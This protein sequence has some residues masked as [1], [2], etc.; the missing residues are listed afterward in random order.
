M[1]QVR[2]GV[3]ELAGLQVGPVVALNILRYGRS[4]RAPTDGK[5]REVEYAKS[6]CRWGL[7]ALLLCSFA[8]GG[9]FQGTGAPT[10]GVPYRAQEQ[11]NYCVPASIAMWR[12]YDG[13]P[14]MSQTQIWNALG[15]PPCTG[16]DA[17]FGVRQ[18]TSS[19]IDAFLNTT[20]PSQRDEFFGRQ[21][22]SIDSR[23]P[24]MVIVSSFRNHVGIINGGSYYLTG[25]TERYTWNTVLFHDPG[26]GPDQEFD[27]AGWI[28]YTCDPSFGYCG[29]IISDGAT[30]AWD[31]H[32][33][34]YGSSIDLYDGTPCCTEENQ[35]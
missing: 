26:I 25:S 18:F 19:G 4:G 10:L 20:S 5:D 9:L 3:V 22:T 23:V 30:F 28:A 13:V 21:M 33:Q 8:C 14:E 17:A 1:R 12:A 11:F 35:N 24:V 32:V 31:F 27:S 34:A 29:Q 2:R 16:L 6:C 7:A 15:G